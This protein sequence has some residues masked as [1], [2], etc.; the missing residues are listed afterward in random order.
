M[1]DWILVSEVSSLFALQI[2]SHYHFF[3]ANPYLLFDREKA[4]GMHLN[5]LP[6]SAVRFEVYPLLSN[7]FWQAC[8][9][10]SKLLLFLALV[11]DKMIFKIVPECW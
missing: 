9:P 2:G 5:V 8:S 10:V 1:L 4:Y 6:G 7:L 11:K 3:E